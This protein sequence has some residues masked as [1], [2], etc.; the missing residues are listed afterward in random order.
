MV[1]TGAGGSRM[2]WLAA[3]VESKI[4]NSADG[5]VAIHERFKRHMVESLRIPVDKVK[6][7]RNWT[8]L[9]ASPN[10]D[11][12]A[13]RA[14]FGW[15]PG[16]IVVLHAGNMGK[17]QGLENVVNAARLAA[18]HKSRVHFVLMGDGNQ[19]TTLEGLAEGLGHLQFI[20]PLPDD[21][22]MSALAAADILLVNELPGV[23]DMA[24]PSKLTSYFNAGV[25][26][27]SATDSGSVTATEIAASKAG[28]RV[29]AANPLSLLQA[30]E[31][32]GAD[33]LRAKAMGRSGLRFRQETLS[34]AVAIGHYDEFLSSLASSRGR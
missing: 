26:I 6:V 1:E 31:D 33:S 8:H 29:D 18:Q 14:K 9:P 4:L 25:P 23:K 2:A 19:R 24:V 5:I 15:N 17:K 27:I 34:E 28:V 11:V 30:A 3:Q 7:I 16:D 22:F 21:D 10:V 13:T 20:S 32:L 12:A